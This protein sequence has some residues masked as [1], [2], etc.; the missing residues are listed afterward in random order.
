MPNLPVAIRAGRPVG[1]S[2]DVPT[3]LPGVTMESEDAALWRAIAA[4]PHDDAPR[5][6]YADW[7]EE[8]GSPERAEFVRIQCRL[9]TLDEDAFDRP[10]LD[11]RERQLWLRHRGTWR[12]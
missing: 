2:G 10:T 1:Y 7:L 3:R 11:R 4:A 12:A 8:N 6:I 9:A 5:L